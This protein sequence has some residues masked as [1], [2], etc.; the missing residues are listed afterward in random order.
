MQVDSV[1]S[2]RTFITQN[3][4]PRQALYQDS[5][6][7]SSKGTARLAVNFKYVLP[8]PQR[9]SSDELAG[10]V[11]PSREQTGAPSNHLGSFGNLGN[12]KGFPCAEPKIHSRQSEGSRKPSVVPT[13]LTEDFPPLPTHDQLQ[14]SL[15]TTDHPLPAALSGSR[16]L[17]HADNLSED[18]SFAAHNTQ[19]RFSHNVRPSFPVPM[20][21]SNFV[22]PLKYPGYMFPDYS[23]PS[24]PL[25]YLYPP[26]TLPS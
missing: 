3:G 8:Q 23:H 24:F 19:S 15:L 2:H 9:P 14:P 7:L 22:P 5:V 21:A 6:H 18:A 26:Y 11:D 17:V 4:A 13:L 16:P 25:P 1:D 12:A 10:N 20:A